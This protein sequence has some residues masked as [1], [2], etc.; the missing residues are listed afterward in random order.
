MYKRQIQLQDG[1][2]GYV[3]ALAG[4]KDT[5]ETAEVAEKEIEKST[6]SSDPDKYQHTINMY[7]LSDY[8]YGGSKTTEGNE[9]NFYAKVPTEW[10]RHD[11]PESLPMVGMA[12]VHIGDEGKFGS[13]KASFY[14]GNPP[15]NYHSKSCLLYTSQKTED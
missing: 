6:A 12:V 9:R 10:V 4:R 8:I 14:P 11:R 2:I 5:L 15:I 1:T 3:P 13:V 7:F